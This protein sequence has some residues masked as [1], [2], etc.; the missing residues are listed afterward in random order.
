[1]K[2]DPSHP[3]GRNQTFIGL[4]IMALSVLVVAVPIGLYL[5]FTGIPD[6]TYWPAVIAIAPFIV[7]VLAAFFDLAKR[8]RRTK[9]GH[10]VQCGYDLRATPDRCPECGEVPLL[11]IPS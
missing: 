6:G 5:V 11:Q 2:T 4:F 10:C 1:M 3:Y 7:L 9:A 8:T